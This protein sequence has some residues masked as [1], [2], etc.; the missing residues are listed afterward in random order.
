VNKTW[1][2][3]IDNVTVTDGDGK[4]MKGIQAVGVVAGESPLHRPDLR[5]D[6]QYAYLAAMVRKTVSEWLGRRGRGKWNM[7]ELVE[8]CLA[9]AYLAASLHAGDEVGVSVLAETA[10]GRRRVIYL[11]PS[12]AQERTLFAGEG[13]EGEV[14]RIVATNLALSPLA[15]KVT[16]G[17]GSV[18]TEGYL[19]GGPQTCLLRNYKAKRA[20]RETLRVIFRGRRNP[21]RDAVEGQSPLGLEAIEERV[22]G[23]AREVE[24]AVWFGRVL[25]RLGEKIKL[26]S[27]Q[28]VQA[29]AEVLGVAE[30]ELT[31]A[32]RSRALA[33][34][35]VKLENWG[36]T[37]DVVDDP[38]GLREMEVAKLA[39]DAGDKERAK[40]RERKTRARARIK[41]A[42]AEEKAEAHSLHLVT[43][44][45]LG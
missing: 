20:V 40:D 19:G 41:T 26:L 44:G 9:P 25:G 2:D 35:R 1:T 17:D 32:Q 38:E 21:I 4:R 31:P 18:I 23:D 13:E 37:G 10:G 34:L 3:A 28:Q 8:D 45:T 39:R 42:T 24:S 43:A 11:S 12:D 29:V 16:L 6:V 7:A 15:E 30:V 27:P 14:V 5:G 22:G 33:H 36:I